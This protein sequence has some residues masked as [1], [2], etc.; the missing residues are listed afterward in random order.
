MG[1]KAMPNLLNSHNKVRSLLTLQ[2]SKNR[3]FC[4]FLPDHQL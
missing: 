4:G 3:L 1:T 2:A